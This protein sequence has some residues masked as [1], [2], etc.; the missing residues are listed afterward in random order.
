ML[1]LSKMKDKLK[2]VKEETVRLKQKVQLHDTLKTKDKDIMLNSLDKKVS[3]VFHCCVNKHCTIL[4]TLEKLTRIEN[5]MS[6]LV[7]QVETMPKEVVER[8][9][10]VKEQERRSRL[11]EEKLRLERQKHE[12]KFK[13]YKERAM[14]ETKKKSGRKLMPRSYVGAT[15]KEVPEED[16]RPDE[17]DLPDYLSSDTEDF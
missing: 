13:K 16:N 11:H 12:L 15:K 10:Q 14:G 2:Q 9:L 6:E 3:E 1:Q 4:G 5:R 17:E 7:E 8:L